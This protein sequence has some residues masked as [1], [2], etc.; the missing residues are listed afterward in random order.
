MEKKIRL[1]SALKVH[2][3]SISHLKFSANHTLIGCV[4]H[5]GDIFFLTYNES[6]YEIIPYCYFETGYMINSINFSL[7]NSILLLGTQAGHVIELK[8]PK[9]NDCN[10]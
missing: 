1:I 3:D 2:K 8:V 4:S 7:N 6:N 10:F 9:F 5:A